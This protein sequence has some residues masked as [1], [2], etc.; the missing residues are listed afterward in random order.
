VTANGRESP[1]I[2]V[3]IRQRLHL[4][5]NLPRWRRFITDQVSPCQ[6]TRYGAL[7]WHRSSYDTRYPRLTSTC[8]SLSPP[9]YMCGSFGD[10]YVRCMSSIAKVLSITAGSP[11]FGTGQA[12][13]FPVLSP[14]QEGAWNKTSRQAYPEL[15]ADVSVRLPSPFDSELTFTLG[16]GRRSPHVWWRLLFTHRANLTGHPI[17]YT[18]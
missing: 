1:R 2:P 7:L 11:W 8:Y 4:P 10:W 14:D 18:S 13:L 6:W 3:Y 9:T 12:H 17:F 15:H 16:I 5:Q